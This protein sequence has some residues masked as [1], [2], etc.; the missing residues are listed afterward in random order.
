LKKGGRTCNCGVA[1]TAQTVL[2]AKQ[3]GGGKKTGKADTKKKK[4]QGGVTVGKDSNATKKKKQ[5]K[6]KGRGKE[7]K[8]K[9]K[10]HT[11]GVAGQGKN[12]TGV[13]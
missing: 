5:N 4:A 1:R 11:A 7:K 6:K 9:E 10:M 3:R 2:H 13:A 12:V 8:K